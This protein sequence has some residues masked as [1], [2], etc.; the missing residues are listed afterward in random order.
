MKKE[1]AISEECTLA[2]PIAELKT[3]HSQFQQLTRKPGKAISG[4]IVERDSKV[5]QLEQAK[6]KY[7]IARRDGDAKNAKSVRDQI[8]KIEEE[9]RDLDLFLD[10]ARQHGSEMIAT[11]AQDAGTLEIARQL[12]LDVF[13][14]MELTKARRAEIVKE[15]LPAA[16]RAYLDLIAELGQTARE[17]FSAA[18]IANEICGWISRDGW[19]DPES[20]F[21]ASAALELMKLPIDSGETQKAYGNYPSWSNLKVRRLRNGGAND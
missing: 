1:K 8:D 2:E 11:D 20:G 5:A 9:I 13:A 12:Y 15:K 4:F 21:R 6:M 17:T 14:F 18:W 19:R 10:V 7:F 16:K 3:R